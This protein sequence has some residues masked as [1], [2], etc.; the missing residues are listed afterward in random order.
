MVVT[1][2]IPIFTIRE[3]EVDTCSLPNHKV[4]ASDEGHVCTLKVH[5]LAI[6][7]RPLLLKTQPLGLPP[8]PPSGD[9][10]CRQGG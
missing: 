9:L 10:L 5:A 3:T 4:K 8:K 6:L 7:I 1:T 2:W